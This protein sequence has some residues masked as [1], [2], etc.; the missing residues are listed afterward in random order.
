MSLPVILRRL[1]QAE[2]DDAADWYEARFYWPGDGPPDGIDGPV[3]ISSEVE[4][5]KD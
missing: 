5:R 4:V 2:F 3:L 1:A